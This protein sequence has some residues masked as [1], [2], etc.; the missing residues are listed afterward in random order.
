LTVKE[1]STVADAFTKTYAATLTMPRPEGLVILPD[2]SAAVE[3]NLIPREP[4]EGTETEA[5]DPT[6]FVPSTAIVYDAEGESAVVWVVETGSMTVQP[7]PVEIVT[8]LGVE[9][10]IKGDLNPG[11]VVVTAGGSYLAVDQ[12]VRLFEG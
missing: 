3:I 11:D 7:R 12:Q 6:F 9:S 1:F 5:E 4:E 10:E 2:M 8:L